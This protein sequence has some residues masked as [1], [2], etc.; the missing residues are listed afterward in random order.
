MP[1]TVIALPKKEEDPKA[2]DA[3]KI[4]EEERHHPT[5]KEIDKT[6]KDTFPASD[7]PGHY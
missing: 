2:K 7:P 4:P 5:E 6:L 3:K 1:D